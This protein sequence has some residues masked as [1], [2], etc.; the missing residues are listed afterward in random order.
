M[1]P[2]SP[3]INTLADNHR[4]NTAVKIMTNLPPNFSTCFDILHCCLIVQC[5]DNCVLTVLS[6][7]NCG[8]S[9]NLIDSCFAPVCHDIVDLNEP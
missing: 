5:A 4:S 2:N 7:S 8:H 1:S 6:D 9:F 3:S